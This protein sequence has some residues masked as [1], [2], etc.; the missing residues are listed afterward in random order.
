MTDYENY[1]EYQSSGRGTVG[2]ALAFLFI[3]LG[4][5]ALA[6]LL[7]APKS[8]RQMRRALRRRYEDTME[9]LT[10][11][12]EEW[13]QRG[14]ELIERGSEL[15]ERGSELASAAREK[16]EPIAKAARARVK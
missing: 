14:S 4:A 3:G 13:K 5:G 16:V 15:I 11:R 12:A 6:A 7:F 1:G 2:T 9:N 10:E 8:G